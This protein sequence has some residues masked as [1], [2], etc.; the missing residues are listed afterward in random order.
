MLLPL[1]YNN[2]L[3]KRVIKT[4]S[5]VKNL[6]KNGRYIKKKLRFTCRYG[7]YNSYRAAKNIVPWARPR[8]SARRSSVWKY[9]LS[10]RPCTPVV[11]SAQAFSSSRLTFLPSALCSLCLCCAIFLLFL[12]FCD[13]SKCFEYLT[14]SHA[15]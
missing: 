14:L 12:N 8:R 4:W 6:I 3:T 13:R 5:V 15:K 1:M 11:P 7:R 9:V 2:I 10:S